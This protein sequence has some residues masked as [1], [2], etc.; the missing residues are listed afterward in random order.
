MQTVQPPLPPETRGPRRWWCWAS[1]LLLVVLASTAAASPGLGAWAVQRYVHHSCIGLHP[2]RG[3]AQDLVCVPN[4]LK[5]PTPGRELPSI[6]ALQR[7]VERHAAEPELL[8]ATYAHS[9]AMGRDWIFLGLR[10]GSA[11]ADIGS[12]TGGFALGLLASG[13]PFET[14][15]EVDVH[16]PSLDFARFVVERSALPGS[17][18]VRFVESELSDVHLPPSSVDVAVVMADIEDTATPGSYQP[19]LRSVAVAMRPGGRVFRLVEDE[20]ASPEWIEA[21]VDD[22]ESAGF[23]YLGLGTCGHRFQPCNGGFLELE[24]LGGQEQRS[25]P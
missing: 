21:M 12:G 2:L 23:R 3:P 1:S 18:R 5:A 7:M 16:A 25:G 4:S 9:N 19:L 11:V 22:W 15:Y 6:E 10:E 17:E 13:L 8:L 14:L 20:R 24:L